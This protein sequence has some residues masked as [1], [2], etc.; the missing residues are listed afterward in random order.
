[1]EEQGLGTVPFGV[2]EAVVVPMPVDAQSLEPLL[3]PVAAPVKAEPPLENASTNRL[4]LNILVACDGSELG[5]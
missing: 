5:M 4:K 2:V 1:M 3:P